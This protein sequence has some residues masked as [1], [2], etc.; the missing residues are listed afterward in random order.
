MKAEEDPKFEALLDYLRRTRGFDFSGYKRTSLMRR[1]RRRMQ[2]AGVPDFVDYM[3]YLEV[4][5]EEFSRLFDTVLINVTGFFRDEEAWK[6]FAA[7]VVPSLTEGRS[8]DRPLS[9]W[10]AGCS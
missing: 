4:H 1:V 9:V 5:P 2:D 8:A 3:D 6:H 7:E 10:S